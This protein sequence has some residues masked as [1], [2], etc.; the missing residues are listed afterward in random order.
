[1]K[2]YISLLLVLGLL[3]CAGNDAR[4]EGECIPLGKG[5]LQVLPLSERAVRV[6]YTEGDIAPLEELIYTQKVKRPT[7]KVSR[8]KDETVVSTRQMRVVFNQT[9]QQLTFLDAKGNI[10]LQEAPSG[11]TVKSTTVGESPSSPAVRALDV[12]QRFL[13][14]DDECLFGTGL[15]PAVEQLRPDGAEP[16]GGIACAHAVG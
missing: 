11:R 7:W 4:M 16:Q 1:M 15:R 2:N 13:S 9:S 12:E 3:G 14:P 10:L 8:S 6:R 5:T